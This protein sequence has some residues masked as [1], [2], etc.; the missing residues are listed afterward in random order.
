MREL[1]EGEHGFDC[2][3][4]VQTARRPVSG[5]GKVMLLEA[6]SEREAQ[7]IAQVGGK[8]RDL[9]SWYPL[10]MDQCIDLIDHPFDRLGVKAECVQAI[11]VLPDRF[12]N[13]FRIAVEYA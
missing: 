6:R 8:H 7:R 9:S 2:R 12:R 3:I 5:E 10:F 1:G 13:G 11:C 4:V